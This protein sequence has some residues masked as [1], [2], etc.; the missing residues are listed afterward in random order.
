[1]M[2]FSKVYILAGYRSRGD[3]AEVDGSAGEI[4]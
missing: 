2:R 3:A 1:M 4:L